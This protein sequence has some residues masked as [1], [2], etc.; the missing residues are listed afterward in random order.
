MDRNIEAHHLKTLFSSD[1][2]DRIIK[3]K[4]RLARHVVIMEN[5]K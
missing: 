1:N 2:V 4:M 3:S 5:E